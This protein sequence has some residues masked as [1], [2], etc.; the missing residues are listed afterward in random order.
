MSDDSLV[1]RPDFVTS[2]ERDF[3][4]LEMNSCA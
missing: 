4:G 1:A 2:T 3:R